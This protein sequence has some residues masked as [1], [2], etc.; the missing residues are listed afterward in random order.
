MGAGTTPQ[1]IIHGEHRDAAAALTMQVLA[2]WLP[3]D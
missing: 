3:A 1:D 2:Q